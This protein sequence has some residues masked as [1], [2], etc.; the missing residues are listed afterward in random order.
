MNDNSEKHESELTTITV[1]VETREILNDHRTELGLSWD[2]YLKGLGEAL[3]K[4]DI[5]TNYQFWSF[6]EDEDKEE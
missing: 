4:R 5:T 1:S 6:V 2:R 3:E